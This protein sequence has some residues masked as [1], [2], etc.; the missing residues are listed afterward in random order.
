MFTPQSVKLFRSSNPHPLFAIGQVVNNVCKRL[1]ELLEKQDA[2]LLQVDGA[3]HVDEIYQETHD[4]VAKLFT[5]YLSEDVTK[6]QLF[7]AVQ[8]VEDLTDAVLP[9]PPLPLPVALEQ[10]ESRQEAAQQESAPEGRRTEPSPD[11]KWLF[12]QV[13]AD[14][15]SVL[16]AAQSMRGV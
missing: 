9:I 5:Y 3:W 12:V 16:Q 7:E 6:R 2:K 1:V 13:E 14:V 15:W 8:R 4:K 10:L 11:F